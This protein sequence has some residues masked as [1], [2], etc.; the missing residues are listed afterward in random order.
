MKI[1][2]GNKLYCHNENDRSSLT[3]GDVYDVYTINFEDFDQVLDFYILNDINSKDW[4]SSDNNSNWYYKKWF[5]TE[6]E[7]RKEKLDKLN[8]RKINY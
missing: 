7:L 1:K 3:I 6:K 2:E 4:Y 8:G 5:Y